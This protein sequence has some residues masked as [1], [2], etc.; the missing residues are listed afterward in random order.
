MTEVECYDF[1][2]ASSAFYPQLA[3][4]YDEV[5]EEWLLDKLLAFRGDDGRV[6]PVPKY[7]TQLYESP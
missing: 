2:T 3:D 6:C 7:W 1:E 4:W 5:N